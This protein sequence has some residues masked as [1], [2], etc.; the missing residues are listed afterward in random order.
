MSR[1]VAR[2][3]V[4]FHYTG[5]LKRTRPDI[6]K[7]ASTGNTCP[8][9]LVHFCHWLHAAYDTTPLC[10]LPCLQPGQLDM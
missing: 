6:P 8:Y 2:G 9:Q 10:T 4:S 7:Y 1:F 3:I 5:E